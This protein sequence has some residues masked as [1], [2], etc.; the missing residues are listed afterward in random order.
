MKTELT[1]FCLNNSKLSPFNIGILFKLEKGNKIINKN[2]SFD[3]FLYLSKDFEEIKNSLQSIP[4]NILNFLYFNVENIERILYNTDNII[5][6]DFDDKNNN[7]FLKIN[8]EKI[9][10]ERKNEIVLLFYISL[11]IKYNKNIVNFSYS[12]ILINKINSINKII[13]TDNIYINMLISKIILELINFYKSNQIFEE[14][15]SK[16]EKE[17]LDKIEKENNNIIEKYINDFQKIG[18]K[19]SQKELKLKGIDLIYSYIINILLKSKDFDLAY[20]IIN[21]LNLE[22]INITETMF[23]EIHKELSS[24]ENLINEYRLNSFDDLFNSKKIDFYYILFKY[25]LKNSIYIYYIDFLKE[26][27]IAI[28]KIIYELKNSNNNNKKIDNNFKDKIIYIIKFFTNSDSD[29]YAKYINLNNNNILNSKLNNDIETYQNSSKQ[30]ENQISESEKE[31]ISYRE[32]SNSDQSQATIR[33]DDSLTDSAYKEMYNTSGETSN[34]Q[35]SNNTYEKEKTINISNEMESSFMDKIENTL[36]KSIIELKINK[37]EI[38]YKIVNQKGEVINYEEFSKLFLENP[39]QKFDDN[40]IN[41]FKKLNSYL[42]KIEEIA[43]N[44]IPKSDDDLIIVIYLKEDDNQNTNNNYRNINSEYSLVKHPFIKVANNQDKNI[45]ND[46]NYKGFITFSKEIA[47][48]PLLSSVKTL[49]SNNGISSTN[50]NAKEAINQLSGNRF[51]RCKKVIGKHEKTAQKIKELEGGSFISDGNNEIFKYNID[52]VV[53]KEIYKFDN[54]YTFFIDKN[55]VIISQKNKFNYLNRTNTNNKIINTKLSCRNLLKLK[56]NKYIICDENAIYYCMNGLNNIDSKF[57]LKKKSY[58]GGIQITDEIA[59]ITSNRLLSKGE[60]KLIFFNSVSKTFINEIEVKNYS[61]T[62]SENNCSLMSI[63]KYENCKIL[64]VAC[65]KYL[66]NDKNGILLL[67]LELDNDKGKKFEKFYDTKNFEVYCF[68]PIFKIENQNI[69]ENNDKA[70][71]KETEY[72]LVGG[73][74]LDKREG[75]IKLYKVIYDDEIE[76][77]EIKFIRDIIIEKKIR[78]KYSKCFK[79]PISSLIQSS[80]GDILTTCYD[81]NVCLLSTPILDS[82]NMDYYDHFFK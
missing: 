43:N 75:L 51:L 25:I 5:Y 78:N 9:E 74:S 60:N 12:F 35:K 17:K 14:I 48:H 21:Q 82:L 20:K 26:T 36:Q 45:L 10:I 59:A 58:R 54:Y 28:F 62:I 16:E 34:K 24:N 76:K 70:K 3:P 15:N 4:Q 69:L 63:P 46:G 47:N 49:T 71:A 42:N 56:D 50:K 13:D 79:G 81:G 72:F 40:K 37:K 67:K 61:F 22:N 39:R 7:F 27:R 66:K 33:H 80:T 19:L 68:C 31:K 30:S 8:K 32:G 29:Y 44:N 65:K 55:E 23:N 64:L 18:L 53:E 1:K 57:D 73:F 77:I 38:K 41:N 11:L 52:Y 6:F 2:K